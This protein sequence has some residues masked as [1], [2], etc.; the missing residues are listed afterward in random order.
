MFD[1][2]QVTLTKTEKFAYFITHSL[3]IK[4]VKDLDSLSLFCTCYIY[5]Y[6]YIYIVFKEK[7][8]LKFATMLFPNHYLVT[9]RYDRNIDF[10]QWIYASIFKM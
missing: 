3:Q 4:K 7:I 2:I 10:R 9:S 1:D 8:G 5:I 6:I